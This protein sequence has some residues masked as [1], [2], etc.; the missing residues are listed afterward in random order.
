MLNAKETV[1]P[2]QSSD[3]GTICNLAHLY[4]HNR[5]SQRFY[6]ETESLVPSDGLYDAT[7]YGRRQPGNIYKSTQRER[8]RLRERE[9]HKDPQR[10]AERERDTRIESTWGLNSL[11]TH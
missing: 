1:R 4:C 10:E 3:R 8:Q 9:R 7:S 6:S 5:T 2:K 11:T